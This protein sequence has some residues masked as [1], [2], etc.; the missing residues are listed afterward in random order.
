MLEKLSKLGF[1]TLAMYHAEAILEHDMPEA[2]ADLESVLESIQIPV[3]EL[4]QGG[5]GEG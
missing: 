2:V 4:V 1:Q 5:G 3:E